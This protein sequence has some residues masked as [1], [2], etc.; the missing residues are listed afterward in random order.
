[1][2]DIREVRDASQT[3]LHG[4]GSLQS[5]VLY[6]DGDSFFQSSCLDG[7]GSLQSADLHGGGL[8]KSTVRHSDGDSLF[9]ASSLH[10]DDGGSFEFTAQEEDGD[11]VVPVTLSTYCCNP[12]L[13]SQVSYSVAAIDVGT[14]AMSDD[15][16]TY[17]S[18]HGLSGLDSEEDMMIDESL[19][20]EFFELDDYD[21]DEKFNDKLLLL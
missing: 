9:R 4:D 16:P 2:D 3:I 8:F 17:G 21:Y 6:V 12:T 13:V 15:I 20:R 18:V 5:T 19:D 1:M 11:G 14:H 10:V 7:Y